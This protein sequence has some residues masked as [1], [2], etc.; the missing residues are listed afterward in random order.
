VRTLKE[1]EERMV[2]LTRELLRA[3]SEV[4][5]L[6]TQNKILNKGLED[7]LIA[8]KKNDKKLKSLSINNS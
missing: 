8:K 2:F 1:I 3:T 5:E 7:F 4:K 6:E